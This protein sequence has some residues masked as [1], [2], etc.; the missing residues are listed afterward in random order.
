MKNFGIICTKLLFIFIVFMVELQFWTSFCCF[1]STSIV[2]LGVVQKIRQHK[3]DLRPPMLA[4][5]SIFEFTPRT[6]RHHQHS[7]P[8]S[9]V[10][11]PH[12]LIELF[13]QLTFILTERLQSLYKIKYHT[14]HVL[15]IKNIPHIRICPEATL[16]ST[17]QHFFYSPPS[18][19]HFFSTP[20]SSP[21]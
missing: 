14:I 15:L 19:Q 16:P 18:G 10:T 20:P 7:T 5:V 21:R 8:P 12:Q 11:L 4:N 3:N 2:F 6:T 13:S 17:C 9:F 1:I